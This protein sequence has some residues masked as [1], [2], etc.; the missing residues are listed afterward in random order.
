MKLITAASALFGGLCNLLWV[1][2]SSPLELQCLLSPLR[3]H[4]YHDYLYPVFD[5]S[6]FVRCVVMLS[7]AARISYADQP[8]FTGCLMLTEQWHKE[9]DNEITDNSWF[10]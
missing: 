6:T 1:P 7:K 9:I 3:C 2:K 4:L 8:R 5:L 10:S